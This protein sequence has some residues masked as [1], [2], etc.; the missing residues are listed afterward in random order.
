LS[1]KRKKIKIKNQI[2]PQTNPTT[3]KTRN[4]LCVELQTQRVAGLGMYR[5]C[6]DPRAGSGCAGSRSKN[7]AR[8]AAAEGQSRTV[9][10][11]RSR[12]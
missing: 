4:K 11:K 3:T 9:T 5:D 1:Q 7:N 10:G 8:V 6:G 2:N 12:R